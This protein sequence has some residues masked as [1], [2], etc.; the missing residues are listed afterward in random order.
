MKVGHLFKSSS[1]AFCIV[2][3]MLFPVNTAEAFQG[4]NWVQGRITSAEDN[5]PL[6]GVTV[7]LLD[8]DSIVVA[9]GST[10][11]SGN[12]LLQ[13]APTGEFTLMARFI[14]FKVFRQ[15]VSLT[16][17]IFELDIEL[18]PGLVEFGELQVTAGFILDSSST[19]TSIQRI[20]STQVQTLAGGQGNVFNM[21]KVTPSV[22]STSDYSSQLIVRGGDPD[23]NLFYLDDI[24]VYSP[25][26]ANGVGSIFNP[27]LIR[28]MDFY[29]GA[30]PARYGDRL[31]SVLA[32]NTTTGDP[33]KAL[34]AKADIDA[35][36]ASA[37]LK[38]RLPFWQSSW[39]VSGRKTYFDSFANT[40][41]QAIVTKN[42]IAFPDFYDFGGKLEFKPGGINTISFVGL[43][44]DEVID[45]IARE[46]QF[47]E[48]NKDRDNFVGEQ[49]SVNKALGGSWVFSP[50]PFFQSRVYANWYQNTGDNGIDGAFIPGV[51]P[52]VG[53]WTP[54]FSPG[55]R[56]VI[57]YSQQYSFDKYSTGARFNLTLPRNDIEVGGGYDELINNL[58]I[59]LDLNAL[60]EELFGSFQR[61]S[62]ILEALG[63]TVN[64]DTENFRYSA[65]VQ[66]R[67]EVIKSTLFVQ[68]GVR[69]A[70]Y[71]IN[72]ESFWLPRFGLSFIPAK[73][74]TIR[75]GAGQYVQSPGFEKLIEPD[76]IF[77]VSKFQDVETLEA[78]RS[79]Q[80]VLGVTK[81]VSDLWQIEVEGYYKTYDNLITNL[82]EQNERLVDIFDPISNAGNTALNPANYRFELQQVYEIS[83]TP[84]NNGEGESM[85]IEFMIQKFPAL[86]DMWSGWFSYMLAKSERTED[87]L[88][89]RITYPFDYDR[90]H[91][92]NLIL[93]RVINKR[94]DI[95]FTWRFGTGL[96]YTQP[97]SLKPMTF[98]YQGDGFFISDA[99]TGFI[100]LNPDF[101]GV[102]NINQKRYR[103]Y[104][105]VD[106]RARYKNQKGDLKYEVFVD[107]IN[108]L[109][110]QNIQSYKYV[111]YIIDP[112]PPGVPDHLRQPTGVSLKKEPIFMYPF[113]PSLGI[114]LEF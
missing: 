80:L 41:A 71:G 10:N 66:N 83:D 9:A 86:G 78:E 40:Y 96:P 21:L 81:A 30:F 52:G 49:H 60:G 6:A 42:D 77:N 25:Y 67:V 20:T 22:T 36:V 51:V 111:L 50:A 17:G 54:P 99:E 108:V 100:Q 113:I 69:Y 28:N 14:G 5:T 72:G 45:W 101:G 91:S 27:N 31:S 76:N 68:P 39:I 35:T 18:E 32:I 75:V 11:D 4:R 56:I 46:D 24:E 2:I 57:D 61:A 43:Y 1:A 90:R 102:D 107:L 3:L 7:A 74:L 19:I 38:G 93:N 109:N 64:S 97:I 37:T 26:Q 63:D 114:T 34:H 98:N 29:A 87:I 53:M 89:E 105:R 48:T 84:I 47:G 44:S 59:D 106:L 58:N 13:R 85:G 103:P 8:S 62:G 110:N 33:G 92:F 12:Y 70:Y 88:G 15:N 94:W 16:G 79:N 95:G 82:Y 73:G 55:D 65:Y 23:Q 112:N 104:N